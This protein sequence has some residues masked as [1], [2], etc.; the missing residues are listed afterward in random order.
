MKNLALLVLVF[1]SGSVSAEGLKTES[2]TRKFTDNMMSQLIDEK[3]NDAFNSAKPYWPIP[4][5]EIDGMVNKINLQ[6]PI[7][8]QRFGKPVG[9]E[10]IKKEGIGK[11]F[12]RY[13]YL[14]KFENH[15]IYW[16]IDFY[17]PH[18]EWK[19]NSVEFLDTLGVLYE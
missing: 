2:D 15:A 3:F 5:V 10:F 6:W 16:R 19:I 1:I 12:L 18:E 17:R 11:S 13:Y 9:M 14:H 4:V 7:V 8:K